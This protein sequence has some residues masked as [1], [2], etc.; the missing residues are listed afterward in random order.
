MH[1]PRTTTINEAYQ[2]CM[3]LARAHYENFP[4]ASL[5]MPRRLR[6]HVAAVY[7]FA[8]LADD[9][10]DEGAA[11]PEARRA[12]LESWREG[13]KRCE[14]ED[15]DEDGDEQVHVHEHKDEDE[16]GEGRQGIAGRHPV[17][18]ALGHTMRSFRIPEQLFHDLID[19]FAQDTWKVRYES[20]D[21]VLEYCRRSANPVGRIILA[22]FGCLDERTGPPADALCTGLQ[23]V[24]FWQDVS[25]DRRIPRIYIPIKDLSRFGVAEDDILSGR[26]SHAT[27]TVIAFEVE[28]TKAYFRDAL[29]LF[30]LVPMRLRLELRAIWRGGLR[31]LEKIEKQRYT[32]LQSR[33]ALSRSDLFSIFTG[34]V[35]KGIPHAG[36]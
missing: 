27:R 10:A 28:R 25:V 32:V 21:E 2:Y 12:N 11:A 20:F 18:V 30:P 7:A 26:D 29:P 3:R 15:E 36:N 35:L 16:N 5:L 9:M 33:P 13:L 31:V 23:L 22:L 8:R 19:A 6:P 1:E 4:V 34:A 17:F 24:N 14:Y